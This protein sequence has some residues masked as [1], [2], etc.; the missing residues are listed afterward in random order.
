MF[1]HLVYRTHPAIS[2]AN[3][4]QINVHWAPEPVGVDLG[5][6]DAVGQSGDVLSTI[7]LA[8]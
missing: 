7:R 8:K 2:D 6:V 4:H 5:L 1:P 3:A